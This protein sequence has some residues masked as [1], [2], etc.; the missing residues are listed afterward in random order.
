VIRAIQLWDRVWDHAEH[1]RLDELA[2][3]FDESA[4]FA[5]PSGRGYG[6]AHARGVLDRHLGAYPDLRRQQRTSIESADGGSVALEVRFIGTHLGPLRH[7]DGRSLA[8][9]GRT[10]EWTAID[11]VHAVDGRIVRWFAVF[12]RLGLLHQLTE[13]EVPGSVP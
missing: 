4:E 11:I 5:T 2:A 8:P 1:G 9:T 12:D 6:R 3:L 10:V 7:P 13:P